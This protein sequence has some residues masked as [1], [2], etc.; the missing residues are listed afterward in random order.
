MGPAVADI[1]P[2]FEIQI[3]LS[4]GNAMCLLNM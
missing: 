1:P 4:E 3:K 2:N